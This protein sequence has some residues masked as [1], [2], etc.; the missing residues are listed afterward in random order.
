M[1]KRFLLLCGVAGLLVGCAS[2]P[3]TGAVGTG[4]VAIEMEEFRVPSDPGIQVYVRNK[5]RPA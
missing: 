1:I 4:A 5:A 3:G 2:S